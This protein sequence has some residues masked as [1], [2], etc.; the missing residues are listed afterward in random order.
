MSNWEVSK[1]LKY[2]DKNNDGLP[3]VCAPEIP[4]QTPKCP[5]CLP[6]PSALVPRWRTRTQN[7]PY[8]NERQCL[9]Q[10]AYRTPFTDTGAY[11]KYGANATEE[12][13][14]L[15]LKERSDMF[16]K[17]A[18]TALADYYNKDTSEKSIELLLEDI[19]WSDWDLDPRP[20]SHLKFLYSVPH[21]TLMNLPDA[22][23]NDEEPEPEQEDIELT[24]FA[25]KM[26]SSITQIRMGLMFFMA[27]SPKII[28]VISG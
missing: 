13:A 10:I 7:D 25:N 27:L 26:R 21:D 18:A 4:I 28:I 17:D 14:D 15:V 16:A 22:P 6:K 12:Q 3:D 5:A 9:Y 8:L 2:Q 19:E 1:F 24:V 23:Y 11:E 20:M